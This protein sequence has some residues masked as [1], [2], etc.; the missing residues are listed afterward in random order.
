MKKFFTVVMVASG[1]LAAAQVKAQNKFGYISSQELVSVMPETK[2]ADSSLTDYRN[3]LIANAQDKQTAFYAAIEKFNTDSTKWTE[4][5]KTVKRQELAKLSQELSGEEERIQQALQSRRDELITPI[6][7]KAYE[8]I[9]AVSKEGNF[10]YIFE[11][12]AILVAP[13]GEDILPLVAKKLNIKLPNAAGAA[14]PQAPAGAR[15]ATN[16]P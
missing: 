5:Q 7:R 13:P 3:A 10:T 2:K 12:E 16:K 4:A 8:A 14:A 9:Q 11:K 6:N 1:L 15:P